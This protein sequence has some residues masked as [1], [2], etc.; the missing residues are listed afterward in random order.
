MCS[1]TW[2]HIG[3]HAVFVAA[4]GIEVHVFEPQPA[5]LH[6]LRCSGFANNFTNMHVNGFG[7]SNVTTEGGCMVRE[8]SYD[9]LHYEYFYLVWARY[10]IPIV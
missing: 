10:H 7:L 6:V 3:V 8:C 5:N 1:L 4:L 2:H 9:L